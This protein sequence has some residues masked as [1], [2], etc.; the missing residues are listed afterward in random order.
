M[1]L[2]SRVKRLE[3]QMRGLRCAWCTYSLCATPPPLPFLPG[4]QVPE[5]FV[6]AV[7]WRC[8]TK[9]NVVG[10]TLRHRQVQSLHYSTHPA[11]AYTDERARA[12]FAY[13][14]NRHIAEKELA[15]SE[16]DDD[17]RNDHPPVRRRTRQRA[18]ARALMSRKARERLVAQS[19]AEA[20]FTVEYE[21]LCKL[22]GELPHDMYDKTFAELEI[23]IFGDASEEAH[24]LDAKMSAL[25]SDV[26]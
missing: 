7:C 18:E 22:L 8:G 11:K 23:I 24:A 12:V 20:E 10:E 9:F 17:S 21:R 4:Q 3:E 15:G 13:V 16:D 25:K 6:F 14:I 1:R 26:D 2:R 5:S 19:R